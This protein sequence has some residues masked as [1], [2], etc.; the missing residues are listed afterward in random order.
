MSFGGSLPALTDTI[1][2]FVNGD[3]ASVVSGTGPLTTASSSS[4]PGS[5]TITVDV[6]GLSAANYSFVGQ[7]G[8]LTIEPA[9]PTITWATPAAITYGTAL[10]PHWTRPRTCR[11]HSS[12]PRPRAPCCPRAPIDAVG[13]LHADRHHPLPP[14]TATAM[15][16]VNRA[17]LDRGQLCDQGLWPQVP[18]FTV[19]YTG[20]TNG[21]LPSSLGG[22]LSSTRPRPPPALS[23]PIPLS[24]VASRRR[25]CHRRS[26]GTKPVVTPASLTITANNQFRAYGQSNPPLTADYQGFVNGDTPASLTAPLTVS[27]PAVPASF[28]GSYPILVAGAV[29]ARLRDSLCRWHAH[30]HAT[31]QSDRSGADRFRHQ[32]LPRLTPHT[33]WASGSLL[34]AAAAQRGQVADGR[35]H[36]HQPIARRRAVLRRTMPSESALMSHSSVLSTPGSLPSKTRSQP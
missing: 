14:V 15:I 12:T 16:N 34:L 9:T 27:T 13:H 3:N 8:A 20:L 32:P 25:T 22:S 10:G 5:Y 31:D 17:P 35:R 23:T 21:D 11:A 29:V 26:A 7:N 6:S 19:T 1:T 4:N 18:A 36:R 30:D 24:R 33:A 2:G 28:A